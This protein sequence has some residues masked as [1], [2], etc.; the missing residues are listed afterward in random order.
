MPEKELRDLRIVG[1]SVAER[2]RHEIDPAGA[3]LG[4]IDRAERLNRSAQRPHDGG[5]EL[6]GGALRDAADHRLGLMPKRRD[7]AV[8][9]IDRE[10]RRGQDRRS[11]EE[12]RL[13]PA[14]GERRTT[15]H[16]SATARAATRRPPLYPSTRTDAA[17][18]PPLTVTLVVAPTRSTVARG[19]SS[20]KMSARSRFAD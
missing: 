5:R 2:L 18:G 20:T 11:D 4:L 14:I 1:E 17:P 9:Q 15:L 7:R 3:E 12:H 16:H 10:D 13:R 6:R 8:L 19:R